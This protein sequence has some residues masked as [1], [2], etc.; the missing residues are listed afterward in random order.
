MSRPFALVLT[1]D[2]AQCLMNDA[3]AERMRTVVPAADRTERWLAPGWA[4]EFIWN[5]YDANEVRQ[6]RSSATGA[7]A[8]HPV[9]V[10]TVPADPGVR[11]KAVFAADMESTLI[12]QELIDELAQIAGC[13]DEIAAIT[14]A[15]MRGEID[16]A[17]SLTE[18]VARLA[19]LSLADINAV[20]ARITPMPGAAGL[21]P[22]MKALGV[23]TAIVSGGFT[24]FTEK[25][26][27]RLGFDAQFGNVLEFENDRL[28]GRIVPPLLDAAAKRDC[29]I[30]LA[31]IHDVDLSR[32]LAVGDGANDL[33][34][35]QAAG[36]GVAFR[37]KPAVRAA[38]RKCPT[39][40]V[41]DH[42]DLSALLALQGIPLAA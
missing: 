13:H 27:A 18:R 6:V 2:P 24:V 33:D 9:D 3:V 1:T 4:L 17:T 40:A 28:T 14:R 36:L 39:G 34:M 31:E 16:F 10:N 42:A 8:S 37:A 25:V 29:L 22:S 26:A 38:M 20:A 7:L 23:H 12:Q 32:T 30:D 5:A 21:A 35:L 41:I 19:G 15:A 11:L